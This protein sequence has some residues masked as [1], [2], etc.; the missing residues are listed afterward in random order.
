MP[1]LSVNDRKTGS[2]SKSADKFCKNKQIKYFKYKT[3]YKDVDINIY[4][5]I[6]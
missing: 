1:D 4:V 6:L 5:L 3:S 2:W